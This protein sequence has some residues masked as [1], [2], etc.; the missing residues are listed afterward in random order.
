MRGEASDIRP[1]LCE[2]A[3][4]EHLQDEVTPVQV[5]AL[6]DHEL[7]VEEDVGEERLQV[8]HRHNQRAV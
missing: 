8:E 3:S 4:F 7:H 2:Y 5:K 6:Q 1:Y